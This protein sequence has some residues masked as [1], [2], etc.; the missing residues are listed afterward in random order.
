[1]EIPTAQTVDPAVNS[2][3]DDDDDDATDDNNNNNNNNNVDEENTPEHLALG[4]FDIP[5]L[6]L[7]ICLVQLPKGRGCT[8]APTKE[9][10]QNNLYDL[11]DITLILAQSLM[12]THVTLALGDTVQT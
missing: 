9:A 7:E 6:P 11:Q 4:A 3:D 2:N 8:L 5:S 1:L 12:Q 10:V